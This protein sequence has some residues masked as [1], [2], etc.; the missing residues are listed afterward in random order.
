MKESKIPSLFKSLT[1]YVLLALVLAVMLGYF[2][3]ATAIR[4]E[5]LGVWFVNIIKCFIPFIIFFTIVSGISGMSSLK[6]VG[7]IG[8]KSLLYFEI[9]TTVSLA[10]GIALGLFFKPGEIGK[11][12]LTASDASKY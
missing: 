6:K 3:P 2:Y 8:I 4:T 5:K 12:G 1:F 9:V 10:I 7:R 11:G